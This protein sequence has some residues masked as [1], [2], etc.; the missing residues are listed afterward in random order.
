MWDCFYDT[1]SSRPKWALMGIWKVKWISHEMFTWVSLTP[2]SA[3]YINWCILHNIP[4]IL[5]KLNSHILLY[6]WISWIDIYKNNFISIKTAVLPYSLVGL[7]WSESI[8]EKR[9]V[10]G[11]TGPAL[12][13]F[14]WLYSSQ[15]CF[16]TSRKMAASFVW[17]YGHDSLASCCSRPST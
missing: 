4:D 7:Y 2:P 5:A 1:Y 10:G 3:V 8:V 17:N 12:V 6:S 15:I 16:G 9:C 11:R 13:Y 14:V